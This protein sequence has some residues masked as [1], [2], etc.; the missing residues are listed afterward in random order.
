M[1]QVCAEP[2]AAPPRLASRINRAAR[3]LAGAFAAGVVLTSGPK[4]AAE[5]APMNLSSS[6]TYTELSDM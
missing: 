6:A 3:F 4:A 5:A 1:I 2:R